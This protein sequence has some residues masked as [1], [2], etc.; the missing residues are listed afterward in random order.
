MIRSGTISRSSK[1]QPIIVLS[2]T[3]VEYIASNQTTK[4][5][6]QMTKFMKKLR[7]MKEK[8]MM[9]ISYDNYNAISL[10]NNP[11]Q[12]VQT[13]HID[14]WKLITL[15]PFGMSH[16]TT[17]K[18]CPC[19]NVSHLK[20]IG[21]NLKTSK[22]WKHQGSWNGT[23]VLQENYKGCMLQMLQSQNYGLQ[24]LTKVEGSMCTPKPWKDRMKD[25]SK[26]LHCILSPNPKVAA[27]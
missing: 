8:K 20:L 4:K 24:Q 6:I 19:L 10:T 11:T 14:E 9:V 1:Q 5:T 25:N 22:K 21:N 17:F 12:H 7:Y 26:P 13:K 16:Y 23:I 15:T 18:G 2:T 27:T 3:K